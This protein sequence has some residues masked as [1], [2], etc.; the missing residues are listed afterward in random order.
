MQ[1]FVDA[2]RQEQRRDEQPT[3]QESGVLASTWHV[4]NPF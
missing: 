2:T 3:E 4:S 1:E